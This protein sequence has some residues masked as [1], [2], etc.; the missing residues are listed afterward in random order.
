MWR[1]VKCSEQPC[2]TEGKSIVNREN[3]K[4]EAGVLIRGDAVTQLE[5]V[6]VTRAGVLV[7]VLESAVRH[8]MSKPSR[9]PISVLFT[10]SPSLPKSTE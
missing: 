5:C 9:K 8:F 10:A 2:R 1:P 6:Y 4:P 7:I 3:P